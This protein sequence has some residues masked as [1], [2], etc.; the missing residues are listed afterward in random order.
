M[1][2]INPLDSSV[3]DIELDKVIF[4]WKENWKCMPGF[5][6]NGKITCLIP[7]TEEY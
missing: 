4:T 5:Y 3:T 6:E 1:K 7:N 2:S